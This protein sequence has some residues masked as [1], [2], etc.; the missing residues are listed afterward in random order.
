MNE[1]LSK[2][3]NKESINKKIFDINLNTS[4]DQMVK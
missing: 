1:N 3:E 4:S 2:Y